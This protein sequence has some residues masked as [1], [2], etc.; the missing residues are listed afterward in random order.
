MSGRGLAPA[1]VVAIVLAFPAASPGATFRGAAVDDPQTTV[2]LR[3]SK[4]GVVRFDY[5]DVMVKCSNGDEIRE[6]GAEHSTMLGEKRRFKDVIAQDLG[7]DTTGESF[8]R[9]RLRGRRAA[10]ILRYGLVYEGGS[11]ESGKVHWKARHKKS[12][13]GG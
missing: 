10:G 1:A 9:G 3:V 4:A 11:C 12:A 13:R 7:E 6:P 2:T 8:I 5:A